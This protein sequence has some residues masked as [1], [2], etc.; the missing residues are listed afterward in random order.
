MRAQQTILR[1]QSG[2]KTVPPIRFPVRVSGSNDVGGLG[3]RIVVRLQPDALPNDDQRYI[4]LKVPEALEVLLIAPS[5]SSD[6]ESSA[7]YVRVALAPGG[8]KSG[9]RVRQET[10]SFLA[11]NSLEQFHAIFLLD[12]PSLEPSA[13]R[14]LENYVRNGGGAAFFPGTNT[15][16]DFVRNQLY[17]NGAGLFPAAPVR[18]QELPP[19]YLTNVSDLR[20]VTQAQT[21]VHPI[22]RLFSDGE[23]PLLGSVIIERYLA[24]ESADDPS[25][26]VWATLRNDAPLVLEKM[27]GAGRTMTFLTSASPT[28]NNWGRSNPSYVVVLLELTAWLSKRPEQSQS[29]LVGDPLTVAI[30][31]MEFEERVQFV[32]PPHEGEPSGSQVGSDAMPSEDGSWAATFANTDRPGF[33]TITKKSRSGADVSELKAVNVSAE[34]GDIRQLDVTEIADILR[35]VH[36]SLEMA[37]GFS[38]SGDFAGKQTVSDGLL[39]LVILLLLSEMLLAGRILPPNAVQR[40]GNEGTP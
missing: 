8:T 37:A 6:S 9:I 2:G 24:I 38:T 20:L 19:D 30:N 40:A 14:A 1:L 23:S 11:E 17:K 12:L 10:P 32:T 31:P 39:Y 29:L 26:H 34:E 21:A 35:P 22:F 25:V 27:F 16:L 36:Q 15:D 5:L 13:I 18:V 28:W 3:H 7:Q 4:A 33:Y